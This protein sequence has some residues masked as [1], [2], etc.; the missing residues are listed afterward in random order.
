MRLITFITTFYLCLMGLQGCATTTAN[1]DDTLLLKPQ[2]I[3]SPAE[4]IS[5]QSGALHTGMSGY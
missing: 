3:A 2:P 5:A 4:R 1:P